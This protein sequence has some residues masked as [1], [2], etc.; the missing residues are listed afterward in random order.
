MTDNQY[1]TEGKRVKEIRLK[2][3]KKPEEIANLMEVTVNAYYKIELGHSG[4]S[5]SFLRIIASLG[6]NLNYILTGKGSLTV[7]Y[8]LEPNVS[9]RNINQNSEKEEIRTPMSIEDALANLQKQIDE[10]KLK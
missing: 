1:I 5:M 10:M 2:L 8:T 3:G 9:I 7:D 4:F 6:G